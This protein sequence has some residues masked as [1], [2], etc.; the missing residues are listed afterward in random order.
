VATENSK[1][2]V[3][4]QEQDTTKYID[5]SRGWMGG[6]EIPAGL[7]DRETAAV[8]RRI[9]D[10]LLASAKGMTDRNITTISWHSLF[11]DVVLM[12]RWAKELGRIAKEAGQ[13]ERRPI[14]RFSKAFAPLA[15]ATRRLVEDGGITTQRQREILSKLSAMGQLF[16]ELDAAVK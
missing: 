1:A 8:F 15:T 7:S 14:R 16:E 11:H 4:T 13:S 2:P 6:K 9:V 12:Q 5:P 3:D 10:P